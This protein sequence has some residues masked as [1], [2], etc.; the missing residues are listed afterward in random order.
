MLQPLTT[1][2][3]AIAMTLYLI[4]LLV[5]VLSQVAS[6]VGGRLIQ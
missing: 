1:E 5:L 4:L 6:S 3:V 2:E